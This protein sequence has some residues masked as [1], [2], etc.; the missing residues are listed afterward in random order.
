MRV[1]PE[2]SVTEIKDFLFQKW[3]FPEPKLV[4]SIIG[5]TREFILN[6]WLERRFVNGIVDVA[7]RTGRSH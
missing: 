7:V 1:D 2:I 4:M 6:D 3:E 5:G